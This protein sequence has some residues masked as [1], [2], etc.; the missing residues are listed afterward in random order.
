[1][2]SEKVKKIFVIC[3]FPE[4]QAAGQRLKYEQFFDHWRENGY[5]IEVSPFMDDAMWAI[6]YTEGNYL[7]KVFGTIKG[8]LRRARDIF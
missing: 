6:V 4:N 2:H 1:M 8:Y 5:E 7:R 3:P